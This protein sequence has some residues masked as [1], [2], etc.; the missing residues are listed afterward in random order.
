[1]PG[2]ALRIVGRDGA[3]RRHGCARGQSAR[4]QIFDADPQSVQS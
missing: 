4:V 1:M 2:R 3:D